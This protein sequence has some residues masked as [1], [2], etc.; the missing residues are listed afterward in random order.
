[1]DLLP[2][3]SFLRARLRHDS[4]VPQSQVRVNITLVEAET[5][6]LDRQLSVHCFVNVDHDAIDLGMDNIA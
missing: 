4:F 2:Q 3:F 6:R 5:G 1:M